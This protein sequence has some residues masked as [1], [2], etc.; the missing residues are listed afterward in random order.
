MKK[1][2]IYIELSRLKEVAEYYEFPL[3]VFFGGDLK[4][5]RK[6]NMSKN[7]EEF[8]RK[9]NEITEQYL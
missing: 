3:A 5:T 8:K 7:I 6:E 4:G 9:L 2:T 1:K